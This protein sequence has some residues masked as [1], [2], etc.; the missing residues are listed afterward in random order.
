MKV[1]KSFI[2]SLPSYLAS[3]PPTGL[4]LTLYQIEATPPT[5]IPSPSNQGNPLFLMAYAA[6]QPSLFKNY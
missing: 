2:S 5:P 3:Q 6:Y 1:L 4:P